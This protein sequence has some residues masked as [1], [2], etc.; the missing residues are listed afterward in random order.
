MI[1]GEFVILVYNSQKSSS[2]SNEAVLK[3]A[4]DI[5]SKGAKPKLLSKLLAE[6]TGKP[7]KEVYDQLNQSRQ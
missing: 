1:K 5:L 3:L 2:V 6:I 4:Q 7:S